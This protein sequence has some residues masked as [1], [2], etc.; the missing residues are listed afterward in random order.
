MVRVRGVPF[1]EGHGQQLL[2]YEMCGVNLKERGK[3]PVH[4]VVQCLKFARGNFKELEG[5]EMSEADRDSWWLFGRMYL[6]KTELLPRVGH[7]G[8]SW[9]TEESAGWW[10]VELYERN[11]ELLQTE[12]KAWF[13]L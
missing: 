9:V 1:G 6:P 3:V 13:P 2:L 8:F 7:R 12:M 11:V 10:E 5:V 4:R